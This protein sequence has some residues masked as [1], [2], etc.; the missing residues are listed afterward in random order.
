MPG[1]FVAIPHISPE[2]G[3]FDFNEVPIAVVHLVCNN[4]GY[5][6]LFSAGKIGLASP[7]GDFEYPTPHKIE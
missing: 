5:V 6:A 3:G 7:G 4:C 1:D 2:A